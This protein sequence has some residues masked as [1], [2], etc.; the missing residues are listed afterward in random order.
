M[1][2]P[3]KVLRQSTLILPIF[4]AEVPVLTIEDGTAYIP[5]IAL[6]HMLGLRCIWGL[7]LSCAVALAG[8]WFPPSDE[9]NSTRLQRNGK[10]CSIRLTSI[11]W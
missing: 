6:C 7:Y 10:N 4:H 2:Q 9:P 5:V 8:N 1:D 3:V 11:F